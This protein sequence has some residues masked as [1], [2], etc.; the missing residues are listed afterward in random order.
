MSEQKQSHKWTA[1]PVALEDASEVF[2]TNGVR[3]GGTQILFFAAFPIPGDTIEF[4]G[5]LWEVKK[6]AHK[7]Q[8]DTS[9]K[10]RELPTVA[11]TYIGAA[12]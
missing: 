9:R 6:I 11:T 7:C 8:R 3:L 5:H 1:Y 10:P 12:K 2:K 4:E